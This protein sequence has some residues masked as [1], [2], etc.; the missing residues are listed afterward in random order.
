WYEQLY[1]FGYPAE[2]LKTK[3]SADRL[4]WFLAL[5]AAADKLTGLHG[6]WK[7]PWGK[8][9]RLQ[10]A[11][12]QP[13]VQHAGVGLNPFFENLPCP[14]AP[15][16][17]GIIF[18]I[19]SSPEIPVVRPQRFAVVGASYMAIVEFGERIRTNSVMPFG[20]SGRRNS[21]HFFDQAKL[22]SAMKLKPAWFYKHQVEEHSKRLVLLNR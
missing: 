5:K 22:Y 4:T 17:L 21:S 13:D 11:A 14:G 6:T 18:T 12:D 9:H 20:S 16:P 7:Y 10:R 8:A 1:G 2:T 15:G 19:Y 3:Y